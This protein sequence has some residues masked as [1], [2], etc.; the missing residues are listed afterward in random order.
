MFNNKNNLTN[1]A[2]ND[3]SEIELVQKEAADN[4][5]GWKRALADYD[6][7][8]KE[9][10]KRQE[11]LSQIVRAGLIEDFLDF[12]D[13]LKTA[14]GHIP[15]EDKKQSWAQGLEHTVKEAK[16]LLA[17]YGVKALET[18][19]GDIF[20]ANLHHAVHSVSQQDLPD[21]QITQVAADAYQI[22]GVLLRPAQVVV[23]SLN[24]QEQ[25]HAQSE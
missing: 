17:R 22:N 16:D 23:N 14:I 13:H 1:P 5:A 10:V 3:N 15:A 7:F 8:R 18:K 25:S 21:Q 2:N 20:D 24:Q 12:F 19:P 4:L 9:T 11:D 6:N